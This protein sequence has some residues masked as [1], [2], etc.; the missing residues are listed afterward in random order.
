[1]WRQLW[2]TT[3]I[4]DILLV[5][6]DS[7]YPLF[8]FNPSLYDYITRVLK[9]PMML[10][11]NKID[12][13]PSETLQRW[14]EYF[15]LRFPLIRV[16]HFS[17]FPSQ[18]GSERAHVEEGS[19]K[20]EVKRHRKEMKQRSKKYW[21]PLHASTL[22]RGCLQALERADLLDEE[23]EERIMEEA[24]LKEAKEESEE[25][26]QQ[27]AEQVKKE[28]EQNEEK[29]REWAQKSVKEKDFITI[30]LVGHPNAGLLTS[31]SPFFVKR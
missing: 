13:V 1:M 28:N 27:D 8:H 26:E 21:S 2:R 9:K 19:E 14:K 4:S 16:T 30:G 6:V 24:N 12:L 31:F 7:R 29:E 20:K 3:E 17:V 10:V 18:V 22:V 25:E 11:F 5:I 23:E 15:H